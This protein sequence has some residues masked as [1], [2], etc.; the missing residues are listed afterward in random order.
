MFRLFYISL[1]LLLLMWMGLPVQAQDPMGLY[2]METIPQSFMINPAMQ[3][4]ANGFFALPSVNQNFKSDVAFKNIFQENSPEWVS[5]LSSKYDFDKLK[6]AT[7]KALNFN[8]SVDVGLLGLGFR[9]GKDYLSLTFSI[10][11][12]MQS[13]LPYDLIRIADDGFPDGASYDFS[14]LRMRGYAYKE[15][16][17]GYSREWTDRLTV[18]MKFKPLFGIMGGTT[19]ISTFKLETSR[20]E[21]VVRVDGS[22]STSAP[23]EVTEAEEDGDFPESIDGK[24]MEDDDWS[25]YLSSFKNSGLAFDFGAVYEF[26]D[27]LTLSAALVN[28]GYIKWKE[29]LNTLSFSGSYS[30]TG[31]DVDGSDEDLDQAFEDLGDSLKTII[32]YQ[33]GHNKFSTGLTPEFYIGAQYQVS[34]AFTLGV[35]SRSMFQKYNFR[36]DFNF[37]ANIQPYSFLAFN[38]N[39]SLRPGGGN[40]LGTGF[41]MLLGPLQLYMLAD[42]IPTRYS[43]VYM[44]EEEFTMFPNARNVSVKMGLNLIF[45]RHGYRD[46]PML[47]KL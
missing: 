4:R 29:D 25:D 6:R 28:L 18:G 38:L 41:S 47:S 34:P 9:T 26:S 10:K 7:G 23:L 14:S 22:V 45:G 13:G 20:Q 21:W 32:D 44:D 17:F 42:Y 3:P 11:S 1:F 39:Y 33:T 19:D 15:L 36:Q 24:E 35:L 31:L 16:S 8:E 43:T 46:R 37:S 12:V 30:F 2:Y 27:R 40:G 5:P